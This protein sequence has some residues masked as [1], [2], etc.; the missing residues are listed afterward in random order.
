MSDIIV[1]FRP[2]GHSKLIEAIKK[3]NTAT[4]S[5]TKTTDKSTKGGRKFSDQIG[6][7]RKAMSI[8]ENSLSTIRSRLLIYNFLMGVGVTQM[9][10]MAQQSAK[11]QNM[12]RGFSNLT[13]SAGSTTTQISKLSAATKGTVSSFGLLQQ[14]NNAMILGVTQNTD[15]MANMFGM[16]KRLG[17]A[18][19]VDT[20]RAVESLITGIGRQSRLMLDNIGIIVKTEDAYKDY[21]ASLDKTVDQLT[22][23]EKKQAFFN[24]AMD[25]ADK[26]VRQLGPNTK[27]VSDQ[28]AQFSATMSNMG[29]DIGSFIAPA[30]GSM[31]ETI[32]DFINDLSKTDL[33]KTRDDLIDIG[34]AAKDIELL[35]RAI[36]IEAATSN[37]VDS[38]DKLI[39]SYS[40][41]V[42]IN[43][44][45]LSKKEL[46]DLGF[47]IQ[48]LMEEAS[49]TPLV[50]EQIHSEFRDAN[51]EANILSQGTGL[52]ATTYSEFRNGVMVTSAA[53]QDFNGVSDNV[54]IQ[55]EALQNGH[56]DLINE[57]G[58][59]TN[60]TDG[61]TDADKARIVQIQNEISAN[62]VKADFLR[63]LLILLSARQQAEKDLNHLRSEGQQLDEDGNEI[64]EKAVELKT[65]L[66][67]TYAKSKTAR[68]DS[69]KTILDEIKAKGLV[70]E[71]DGKQLAAL[72][73][74][75]AEYNK[76]MG[77]TKLST[78]ASLK[79]VSKLAGALGALAGSTGKNT[80]I[81]ARFAQAAAI[82]DTYAGANK[83]FAQGGTLGF[84]T[85]AAIIAQGLANV[86]QIETQ[87][88]KMG[89]GSSGGGGGG[90]YGS[91]EQGG[92]VGGN[93]HSQGGTIIEAERGEF[94]MSRN[95]V[96]S[97]GLETLNQMNQSGGGGNINVSVSGNVLT[98]DFV[99]GEL[100]ESIKEAVRRGSDFGIG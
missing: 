59:L 87:L 53:L 74:L 42:D 85:G 86:A 40:E 16:A 24:A 54:S 18:L 57:L 21:A 14:A 50:F 93:R 95:A 82:I 45:P 79:D 17:D 72:K 43:N 30:L 60:K 38:T 63:Q 99:E 19:G 2:D 10:R 58:T 61:Q 96:E 81:A 1:R 22:D 91:F 80:K 8:F 78:S 47:S 32:S 84:V 98:Q 69:L 25:A 70:S 66:T 83:A 13:K 92:Y 90:V 76:L 77:I 9:V 3:L 73:M 11:L 49:V 26:K 20:T 4:G 100:A 31:A 23:S 27:Q 39:S 68:A 5:Y 7:N 97:I 89:G 52:L 34:V 94:V 35:N 75:Q 71:L 88:S 56:L 37:F 28:F 48:T 44:L 62:V 33:E 36:D 65:L 6:R 55:L 29:M 41:F 51:T 12:E 64:D 46:E 67:E 15:E